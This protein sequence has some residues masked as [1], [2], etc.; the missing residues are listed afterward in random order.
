MA[1]ARSGHGY[2]CI[3]ELLL[4]TLSIHTAFSPQVPLLS[5]HCRIP[6]CTYNISTPAYKN[7]PEITSGVKPSTYIITP[8]GGSL[9]NPV[10]YGRECSV[11]GVRVSQAG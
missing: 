6:F 7:K 1:V 10:D 4:S 8:K 3:L 11:A 2:S 9:S 5:C